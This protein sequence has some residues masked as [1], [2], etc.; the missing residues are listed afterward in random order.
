MGDKNIKIVKV[1]PTGFFVKKDEE[2]EASIDSE[3]TDESSVTSEI[4]EPENENI[5]LNPLPSAPKAVSVI[6]E[7][8]VMQSSIIKID[9]A[10]DVANV[11]SYL[12][13]KKEEP[14]IP[15]TNN[16]VSEETVTSESSAQ[17]K[18]ETISDTDTD[19]EEQ[20][21]DMDDNTLYT[22]LAAVLEDEDGDNV[23]DNLKNINRHLE[24][25]NDTMEKILNEY[26]EINKE[27]ARERKYME[28]L[29]IAIN[30]Q[31]RMMER[32]VNVFDVFLKS[33]GVKTKEIENEDNDM[34]GGLEEKNVRTDKISRRIETPENTG[35][36]R[37]TVK[38]FK[39]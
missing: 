35:K 32:L 28:Q 14:E 20:V 33:S 11:N 2:D 30:N 10:N 18:N 24:K 13:F 6:K 19:S 34:L 1:D 8:E 25:H 36:H 31:N 26:S 22:A 17:S 5:N 29:S 27:R 12:S 7:P 21:I 4:S 16:T 37:S 3:I 38:V 9:N 15:F 39:K 23:S